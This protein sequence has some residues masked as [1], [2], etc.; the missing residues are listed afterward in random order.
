MKVDGFHSFFLV[1]KVILNNVEEIWPS[2]DE[3]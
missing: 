2:L 1:E 3:I